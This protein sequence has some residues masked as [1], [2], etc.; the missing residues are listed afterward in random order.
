MGE[1]DHAR[2]VNTWGS[3][4]IGASRKVD[5]FRAAGNSADADKFYPL[6][7]IAIQRQMPADSTAK[8]QE[9]NLAIHGWAGCETPVVPSGYAN[10]S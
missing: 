5:E 8:A 10:R 1:D 7:R 2:A 3:K 6:A 9:P 4:A